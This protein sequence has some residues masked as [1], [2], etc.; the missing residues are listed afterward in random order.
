MELIGPYLVACCLLVVAGVAKAIR[1]D[2]TARA[3]VLL[4]AG[5]RTAGPGRLRS[6]GAVRT[7]IRLGATAEALLGAAALVLPRTPIAAA[8]AASYLVFS[9]VVLAAMVKGG[10]LATCGCFGTP[11]TPPTLVHLGVDLLLAAAAVSVAVGAPDIGTTGQVLS[12]QPWRGV[13]LVAVSALGAWLAYLTLA[14]LA[15]LEAVRRQ[16]AIRTGQS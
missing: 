10:V 14:R 15:S 5:G 4:L 3:V 13:P 16:V 2:D 1:P 9:A 12:S 8:V 6:L 11:D 7:A